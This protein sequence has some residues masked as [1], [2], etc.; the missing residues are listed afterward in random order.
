MD[1]FLIDFGRMA[2]HISNP[3]ILL[4]GISTVRLQGIICAFERRG[5]VPPAASFE[6][7][8]M[9]A[10]NGRLNW[11]LQIGYYTGASVTVRLAATI[12]TKRTQASY[13]AWFERTSNPVHLSRS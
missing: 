7:Q 5:A 9:L 11:A 3:I 8:Q 6:I 13:L 1:G 12:K 2:W 4:D 10:A